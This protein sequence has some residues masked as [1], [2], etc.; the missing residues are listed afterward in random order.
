MKTVPPLVS[1]LSKSTGVAEPDVKRILDELGL[2][3]IHSSAVQTNG[4]K[5]PT[6]DQAKLG[7]KFGR[8][9]IIV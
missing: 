5:E 2:S 3:R 1:E 7:F 6:A 9:T 8:A 4:G